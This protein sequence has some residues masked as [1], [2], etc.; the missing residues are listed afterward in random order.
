MATSNQKRLQM[1]R[2]SQS[3]E[4]R[5]PGVSWISPRLRLSIL[6]APGADFCCSIFTGEP[7]IAIFP[8]VA[9][10][11]RVLGFSRGL[12]QSMTKSPRF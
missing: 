8:F 4:S 3:S 5:K 11:D 1:N 10:N 9:H 12:S 7:F 2:S 6:E